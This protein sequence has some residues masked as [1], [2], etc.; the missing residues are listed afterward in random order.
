M[1][2]R[3]YAIFDGAGRVA[4]EGELENVIRISKKMANEKKV[5]EFVIKC[6]EKKHIFGVWRKKKGRWYREW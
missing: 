4:M 1:Y 3:V 5:R 6:Q 2:V